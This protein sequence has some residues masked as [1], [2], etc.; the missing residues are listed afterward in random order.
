MALPPHLL[1][2]LVAEALHEDL[3]PGDLTTRSIVPE[4]MEGAAV[5]RTRAPV[6]VAG[7]GIA[8]LVFRRLDP[9]LVVCAR[10]E[11]GASL[12]AGASVLEL[13]GRARALLSGERTALNLLGR[14][15]GIATLTRRF[16]EAAAPHR[17]EISDTRKTTPTLRVV[18]KYAVAAAGG[19]NHRFGLWDAI[20]IKDNHVDLAGGVRQAI[21]RARAGAEGMQVEVEVRDLR[22]LREALQA[23]ADAVLL[24]NFPPASLAEAVN[25]ARGKAKLEVSGGVTLET[26]PSIAALGVDRISIGALTHSAASADLTMRITTCRT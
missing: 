5:I 26:I 15:S 2:R 25:L 10:A 7:A 9:E 19:V 24:D 12:P 16:I 22:E 11:E 21:E 1:A 20:L 4:G 17:P 14:L 8:I 3:G 6:V 18:E 13:R 23:G